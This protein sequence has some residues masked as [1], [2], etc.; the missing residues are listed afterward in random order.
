MPTTLTGIQVTALHGLLQN[1]GM[2]APDITELHTQYQAL[3][4]VTPFYT[5][6]VSGITSY[7]KIGD[8]VGV[9]SAWDSITAYNAGDL[10]AYADKAFEAITTTTIGESPTGTVGL[11]EWVEKTEESYRTYTVSYTVTLPAWI[12]NSMLQISPGP[13]TF[14]ANFTQVIYNKVIP[15]T[16]T[17]DVNLNNR[18]VFYTIAEDFPVMVGSTPQQF[19]DHWDDGILFSR[20]WNRT[21]LLFPS[22]QS[23]QTFANVLGQAQGYAQQT[24]SVMTSAARS[25]FGS[26]NNAASGAQSGLDKL[27]GNT[28]E[29]L[30]KV[31]D[32]LSRSGQLISLQKPWTSFSAIGVLN[33]VLDNGKNFIGNLHVKVFDK[34]FVNPVT[35]TPQ[36]IDSAFVKQQIENSSATNILY[37]SVADKAVTQLMTQ[38]LDSADVAAIKAFL[39]V[40]ASANTFAELIDLQ[41]YWDQAGPIVLSS[42]KKSSVI[43]AIVEV[44]QTQSRIGSNSSA[45]QLGDSM[46]N[47]QSIPGTELN[48]LTSPTSTDQ[49]QSLLN[50]FGT[51]SGA[52]GSMRCEDCLGAV[53]YND[54]LAKAIQ[55]LNQFHSNNTPSSLLQPAVDAMTAV[56]QGSTVGLAS[57]T[58]S[59]WTTYTDW[60]LFLIDVKNF[61][62]PIAVQLKNQTIANKLSDLLVPYNRIAET[63]NMSTYLHSSVPFYTQSGGKTAVVNFVSTLPNYGKNIDKF[64]AQETIELCSTA[65]S[66]TGQAVI[67]AMREGKNQK[68][69]EEANVSTDA[70]SFNHQTVPVPE[71]G[72]G[73]IGGGAWPVPVDPYSK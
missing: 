66:V 17:V 57:I 71:T 70:N 33:Y 31:G 36:V 20:A 30:K 24:Q 11:T 3:A 35:Q 9:L 53:Y 67:A 68:A 58:V 34:S 16:T 23:C 49:M 27:T 6:V 43:D 69:L 46:Q 26:A 4:A 63:H 45:K 62:D 29:G 61:V 41:K 59:G 8:F 72:V 14:S 10:V 28:D 54:A 22:G 19:V 44:A 38:V 5:T 51:G 64:D 39:G 48:S 15:S 56:Q 32:A 47:M 55:V 12:R 18:K 37:Q 60:A 50:I 52:N 21:D 2:A 13:G 25:T 7:T 40:T 1:E 73:L 65:S 42:T